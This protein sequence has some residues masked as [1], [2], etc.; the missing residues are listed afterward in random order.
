MRNFGDNSN[1]IRL[2]DELRRVSWI[3]L[4]KESKVSIRLSSSIHQESKDEIR[5]SLQKIREK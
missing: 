1:S 2:D 5:Q 4:I 3:F